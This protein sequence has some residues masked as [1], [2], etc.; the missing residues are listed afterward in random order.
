[1]EGL[2]LYLNLWKNHKIIYIIVIVN[3]YLE[4]HNI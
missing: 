2:S 1:M 3:D 4:V